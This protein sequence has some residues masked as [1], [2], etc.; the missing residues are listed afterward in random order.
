MLKSRLESRAFALIGLVAVNFVPIFVLFK[1]IPGIVFRTI[2]DEYNFL[3]QIK[4]IRVF[5]RGDNFFQRIFFIVYGDNY[6]NFCESVL[7][8]HINIYDGELPV[9]SLWGKVLV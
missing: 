4:S 1:N 9:K 3:F 5:N 7:A 8:F 6:A 2:V